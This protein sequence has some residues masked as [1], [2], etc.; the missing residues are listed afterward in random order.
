MANVDYPTPMTHLETIDAFIQD[1]RD[2][3]PSTWDQRYV[4]EVA[5]RM[6]NLGWMK[7]EPPK[8]GETPV[9][10]GR[11]IIDYADPWK[12]TP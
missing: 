2:S 10:G 9:N 3:M 12:R 7:V 11:H 5:Y 1:M 6:V 4:D 8:L